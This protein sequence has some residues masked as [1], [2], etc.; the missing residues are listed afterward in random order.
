MKKNF[1]LIHHYQESDFFSIVCF[2]DDAAK[3]YGVSFNQCHFGSLRHHFVLFPNDSHPIITEIKDSNLVNL[4]KNVAEYLSI[5]EY[6]MLKK[7]Y[8]KSQA[9]FERAKDSCSIAAN[10]LDNY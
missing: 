5:A 6:S 8:F 4:C 9:W 3:L 10:I 7:S 1:V 2:G